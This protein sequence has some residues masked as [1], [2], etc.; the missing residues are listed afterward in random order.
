MTI[1]PH[2]VYWGHLAEHTDMF[3]E[4]YIGVTNDFERR[5]KNHLRG[6]DCH[7]FV[8]AINLHGEKNIIFTKVLVADEDYAYTME[9]KLR[10]EPEIGWNIAPGGKK[11]PMRSP[12]TRKKVSE[13]L[14]GEKNQWYG[15]TGE[16]HP[17][18]GYKHSEETKETLRQHS[19]TNGAVERCVAMARNPEMIEKRRKKAIGK[20]RNDSCKQKMRDAKKNVMRSFEVCGKTFESIAEF[21]K[22]TNSFSTTIRRWLDEGRF[23]KLEE[24]YNASLD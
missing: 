11:S 4:G 7:H 19:L 22:V 6:S 20:K 23:D 5:K 21:S 12:E 3:S 10:P 17:L 24:R 18:F 8:N 1:A 13:A 15:V 14:K 16:D 2:Y 9:G